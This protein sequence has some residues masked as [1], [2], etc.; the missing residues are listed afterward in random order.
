MRLATLTPEHYQE[1]RAAG[2]VNGG[3]VPK[4]EAGLHALRAHPRGLVKIAPA[5]GHD[6]V[7]NALEPEV[8]TRFV[9]IAAM[10]FAASIDEPPPTASTA[11][12]PSRS[13]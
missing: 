11:S 6:A 3:M 5:A 9:A 12:Q 8:G 10:I 1:L 4:I 7:Q 13:S 2:V